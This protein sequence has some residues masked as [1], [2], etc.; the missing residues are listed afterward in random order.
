MI[1]TGN[2]MFEKIFHFEKYKTNVKIEIVAG[3]TTFMSMAYIL[4][5]NPLLLSESGM[6]LQAAFTA[7][8]WASILPTLIMGFF[9]NLPIALAPGMGVNA[10]FT[11]TLVHG[12]GLDWENALAAVFISGLLF[13][14]V[15]LLNIPKYIMQA[16]PKELKIAIGV[17]IGFFITL[18]GFQNAGITVKND[19]T[20]LMLGDLSQ[21]PTLLAVFGLIFTVTLLHK[22]VKGALLW[23]ILAITFIAI[24]CGVSPAP[25]GIHDIISTDIPSISPVFLHLQFGQVLKVSFIAVF[26]SM[27]MV[28]LFNAMGTFIGLSSKLGEDENGVIRGLKPA[29]LADA[30][31][32]LMGSLLGTSPVTSY[33]ESITGITEGGRTGLVAVTC[34]VLFLVSLVFAPLVQLIPSFATAPCLILVGAFMMQDIR[35]IDFSN[36]AECLPAFLVIVS[37]PFT[38]NIVSGFGLGFISYCIIQTCIGKGKELSPLLWLISLCFLINFIVA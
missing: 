29:T 31:G 22:G 24:L 23:G 27:T 1:I 10:F 2:A 15:A 4:L 18:I 36:I 11:Y 38:Y 12:M 7:T 3:F 37:M 19:A 20:M 30:T 6:P 35:E 5:V 28:D 25:K 34:A 17:G 32:T 9:A 14:L 16:V 13:T 33:L 26:F 8:I 21:I